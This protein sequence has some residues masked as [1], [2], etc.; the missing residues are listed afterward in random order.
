MS[1]ELS[2]GIED[3]DERKHAVIEG[4]CFLKTVDERLKSYWGVIL[5]KDLYFYREKK[6]QNYRV[7]HSL[8]GTFVK[9]MPM[10]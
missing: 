10:E 7:I 2:I 5:G 6:D 8:V 9:D 3:F 1:S 4:L